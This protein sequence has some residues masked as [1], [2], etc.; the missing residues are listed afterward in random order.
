MSHEEA[1]NIIGCPARRKQ[2]NKLMGE[3]RMARKFAQDAFDM[4]L[5]DPGQA[6]IGALHSGERINDDL[7]LR[8]D[9]A[10]VG[11]GQEASS[12]L[13]E[14]AALTF[15]AA[16]EF[17]LVPAGNA[18]DVERDPG[19]SAARGPSINDPGENALVAAYS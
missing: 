3:R 16:I 8:G 14:D 17:G 11:V 19:A 12:S 4:A 6:A 10:G 2:V 18:V 13:A 9:H 7:Q 1:A 15:A 5:A